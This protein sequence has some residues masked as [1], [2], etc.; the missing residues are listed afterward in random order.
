MK[1]KKIIVAIIILII[2]ININS[3][4]SAK[5]VFEYVENAAKLDVDRT[6]PNLNIEY[7]NK[8]ITNTDVIV[9]ITS[10]ENIQQVEGWTLLEDGKTLIKTY[11]QN[12]NES[13][14]IKDLSG[15][16]SKTDVIINNIDK[17]SPLV[18]IIDIQNTNKGY[19]KYA[20]KTHEIAIKIKVSD[21]NAIID[22]FQEFDVLVGTK[23][24]DCT[25]ETEMIEKS[26]NY[27]I[28]QIRLTNITENG[29][30]NIKILENSFKDIA[31]NN[32]EEIILDTG[33]LIDNIAPMAEYS[34]EIEEDGKVLAVIT[35]NE[36][37]RRMEGWKSEQSQKVNSKEFISDI[38]YKKQIIDFAGNETDVEIKIEKSTYLELDYIAHISNYGWTKMQ[39]N[40]AG[41]V[42]AGNEYKIE[43]FL[44]RTGEN[45]ERDFLKTAAYLYTYWGEGTSA[46]SSKLGTI[47][48]YGY[49][50]ISG[51]KT[52]ENSET[53]IYEGQEYIILGGEGVN[54][55]G[56]TDINGNN[57]ISMDIANQYNYGISGLKLE[58][59]D[60]ENSII[61]QIFFNDIG[62]SQTYKNGEEAMKAQNKII[63][64]LKI[65]VVP[66]SELEDVIQ[67]WNE[68]TGTY[69]LN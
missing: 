30:L 32:S 36:G 21:E 69:N 56:N 47:Y 39:N 46:K 50:P 40:V 28:Y 11:D 62:W 45:V 37:I 20:N 3:I 33:I 1:F 42:R 26:E 58:L 44:I 51:Y 61:Y 57:P 67:E 13:I 22:N 24:N 6:S 52:L 19:E 27:I 63:E 5:Y 8:E 35:S 16:E 14:I 25:K 41:I 60:D 18:E 48:N 59:K 53:V 17:N 9:K 64:A 15:N 68:N 34:Q 29:K 43:G 7:S 55:A 38:Y 12:V 54:L 2:I 66:T 10:N 31:E 4:C 23:E 65:A 49:N